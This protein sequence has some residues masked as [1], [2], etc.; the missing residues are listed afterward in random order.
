MVSLILIFVSLRTE[1]KLHTLVVTPPSDQPPP[2]L[3]LISCVYVSDLRSVVPQAFFSSVQL[4]SL[5]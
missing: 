4:L 3:I 2:P 5:L 1:L